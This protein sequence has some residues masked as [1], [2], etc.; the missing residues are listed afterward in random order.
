MRN[1]PQAEAAKQF[2]A[3]LARR[4]EIAVTKLSEK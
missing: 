3:T 2:H 1:R 4:N